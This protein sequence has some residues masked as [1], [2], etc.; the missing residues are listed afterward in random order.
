MPHSATGD[1][2]KDALWGCRPHGKA[3]FA[4]GPHQSAHSAT[5]RLRRVR[6]SVRARAQ[7]ALFREGPR[8]ECAF[9]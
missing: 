8:L 3:H 4:C 1:S 5:G 6:F 2:R 7:S 9:P